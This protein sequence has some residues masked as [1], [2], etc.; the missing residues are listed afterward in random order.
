MLSDRER[1]MLA[2]IE[3]NLIATDPRLVRLFHTHTLGPRRSRPPAPGT[4]QAA[5]PGPCLLLAAGLALLVVGGASA[6]VPLAGAGIVLALLA[7]VLA[8]AR[9]NP[10]PHLGAA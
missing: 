10:F 8:T 5:G 3:Q 6:T 7:L 9:F 2:R 4:M 1:G